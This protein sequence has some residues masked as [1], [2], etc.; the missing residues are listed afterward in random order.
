MSIIDKEIRQFINSE[1]YTNWKTSHPQFEVF[2]IPM[3][4]TDYANAHPY[5]RAYYGD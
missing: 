5:I 2:A 4:G 1:S 3:I